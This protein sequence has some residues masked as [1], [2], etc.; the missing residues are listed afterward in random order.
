DHEELRELDGWGD[1][2]GLPEYLDERGV[3]SALLRNWEGRGLCVYISDPFFE[4]IE[5]LC[6]ENGD[7]SL[8]KND[9]TKQP[10][11]FY[12]GTAADFDEFDLSYAGSN[13]KT[14]GANRAIFFAANPDAASYYAQLSY[15]K[16]KQKWEEE[17]AMAEYLN[18]PFD[19]PPPKIRTIAAYLDIRNPLI[20]GYEHDSNV[21]PDVYYE[22][23]DDDEKALKYA[24]F[25]GY[26]A[27]VWPYGNMTNEGHTVAVFSPEQIRQ[28][29]KDFK[30][31]S[32]K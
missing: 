18:K 14:P 1:N 13:T 15:D 17:K 29:D 26:D 28:V 22:L 31:K 12:H 8:Q 16:L 9:E 23:M 20:L 19:K 32:Q 6:D 21:D 30:A 7:P 27:V 10:Q 4:T 3:N 25:N 24:W 2:L 11:V 5:L